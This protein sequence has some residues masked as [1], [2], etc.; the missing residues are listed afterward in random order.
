MKQSNEVQEMNH[1]R[2]TCAFWSTI[3]TSRSKT[4]RIQFI[5]FTASLK[6]QSHNFKHLHPTTT[7][8]NSYNSLSFKTNDDAKFKFDLKV[9]SATFLLVSFFKSKQEHLPN[10][11]KR[12]SFHLKSSFHSQENQILEFQIFKFHDVIKCLSIK[13]EVH[14][15]E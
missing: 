3:D 9:V 11:E 15:T 6:G 10:Q 5:I 1:Y 4:R 7:Y 14:F 13:Q 2:K 8:F 12:F